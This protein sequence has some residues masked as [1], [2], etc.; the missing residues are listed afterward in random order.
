V[1][2]REHAIT[3]IDTPGHADFTIEVERALRVLD[4]A[5]FVFS[6]VEGVQAQSFAV[7]RQMRRHGVPRLAFI[8]KMDR[9]GADPF[10]VV[11]QL[12]EKLRH[13]AHLVTYPIGAEDQFEG[14]VDLLTRD[15]M[16]FDGDNGETVRKE[17]CPEALKAGVEEFRLK[18]VEALGDFDDAI[19]EVERTPDR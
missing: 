11:R 1:A 16:Y 15:A 2:W 6:A 13:N 10:K 14:V 18:L 3:I 9:A 4:G 7:D 5:V 17:A 19:A 8:N 12:R